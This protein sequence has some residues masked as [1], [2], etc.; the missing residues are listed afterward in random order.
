MNRVNFVATSNFEFLKLFYGLT[1]Q[2]LIIY[3]D[4]IIGLLSVQETETYTYTSI[5]VMQANYTMALSLEL[6]LRVN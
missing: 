6:P 5:E 1:S 4:S 3:Q 2:Y